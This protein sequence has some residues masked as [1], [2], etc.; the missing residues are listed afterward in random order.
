M[1]SVIFVA[2]K[3]GSSAAY[4]LEH[5][6]GPT[7]QGLAA[8]EGYGIFCTLYHVAFGKASQP[9]EPAQR[10]S[11]ASSPLCARGFQAPWALLRLEFASGGF[12]RPP[13]LLATW[14]STFSGVSDSAEYY[15]IPVSRRL[16]KTDPR[17]PHNKHSRAE[18]PVLTELATV[19]VALQIL[20][21]AHCWQSRRMVTL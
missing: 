4:L 13:P 20:P 15:G 5:V 17:I 18:S 11:A 21:V 6:F 3:A 8:A 10:A 16:P 14:Y 9:S 19:S 1:S 7:A 12:R 2:C